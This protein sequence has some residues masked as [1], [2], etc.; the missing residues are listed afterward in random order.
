MPVVVAVPDR[1]VKPRQA[2]EPKVGPPKNPDGALRCTDSQ[3]ITCEMVLVD[4]SGFTP[5]DPTLAERGPSEKSNFAD[6]P[7]SMSP[8]HQ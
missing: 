3:P 8:H 2:I 4:S 1:T 5:V 6:A 7:K